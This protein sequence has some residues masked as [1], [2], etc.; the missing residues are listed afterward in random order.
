MQCPT[1]SFSCSLACSRSLSLPPSLAPLLSSSIPPPSTPSLISPLDPM[2]SLPCTVHLHKKFLSKLGL[3]LKES[4]KWGK[5]V[6][7]MNAHIL[8]AALKDSAN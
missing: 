7:K 3:K 1:D 2:H 5:A 8:S 4:D 6:K